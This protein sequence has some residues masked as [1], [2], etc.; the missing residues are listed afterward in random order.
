MWHCHHQQQQLSA[1]DKK[2]VTHSGIGFEKSKS[3]LSTAE[4]SDIIGISQTAP[5]ELPNLFKNCVLK[6][7][8]L[9]DL[10]AKQK[11]QTK[12]SAVSQSR[13]QCCIVISCVPIQGLPPHFKTKCDQLSDSQGFSKCNQEMQPFFSELRHYQCV[14]Y[15]PHCPIVAFTQVAF[16][17]MH[18]RSL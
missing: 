8:I 13:K 7:N 17:M 16:L 3:L 4:V 18:L 14:L 12:G 1:S 11:V 9:F 6:I 2:S 15:I 10:I 5:A